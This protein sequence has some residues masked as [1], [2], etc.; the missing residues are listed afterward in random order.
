M[1][2]ASPHPYRTSLEST[3]RRIARA[4]ALLALAA[5][6]SR[7]LGFARDAVIAARLGAG[8]ETDAYHAA[9]F[10]PDLLSY[11]LSGGAL[12]V[13][14][15]PMFTARMARHDEEGA[16]RLFSSVATVT[17]AAVVATSVAAW[18]AAPFFVGAS[19]G[20]SAEQTDRVVELSRV[21]LVGPTF[22]ALGGLLVTTELERRRFGASAL[23][24]LVYNLC[25]IIGGLVLSPS[26]GVRG[27]AVGVAVG[28]VLGPFGTA[29][30]AARDRVRLVWR[31]PLWNDDVRAYF[32]LA[33]PVML[34]ASL[35]FAD[36]WI[37]RIFASTMEAGTVTWLNNARRLVLLPVA[38][39]GQAAGQAA[40]PYLARLVAEGRDEEF[41]RT[42]ATSVGAT[43]LVAT[44]GAAALVAGAQP[45]VEFV[46]GRGAYAPDDVATTVGLLRWMAAAA[47]GWSL[48]VVIS[49][50]FYA[51]A[52][53]V[54]PMGVGT[55]MVAVSVPIYWQLGAQAGA[56]GL[57]AASALAFAV[58]AVGYA[59]A[60]RVRYGQGLVW[61][62]GDGV[63]RG[64]IAGG[65]GTVAAV[66]AQGALELHGFA[67]L[68]CAGTAFAGVATPLALWLGGAAAAPLRD[69]LK[70]L[71]RRA[72][73]R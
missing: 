26:L 52:N 37:T 58:S 2:A 16:W 18:I 61:V 27:F 56:S 33:L 32:V 36:E 3:S 34:G 14:F 9:F 53:T 55:V 62:M 6:A 72:R 70:G 24:P 67:G 41:G 54:L 20:F 21:L 23:G 57:A 11:L 47:I 43:A 44:L 69:R 73:R 30:W 10:L 29:A 64:A 63:G 66:T 12:S 38:F 45:L 60:Y 5:F 1:T 8:A 25:I 42:Y 51:R 15:L 68:A 49:R 17:A 50:G 46:Y 22:F 7:V 59:V 28:S 65:A 40:L 13:A 39:V 71:V 35:A 31:R 48:Q 4:A 19:Y